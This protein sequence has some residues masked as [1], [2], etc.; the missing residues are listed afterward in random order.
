MTHLGTQ[1]LPCGRVIT[2]FISSQISLDVSAYIYGYQL[3]RT[4]PIHHGLLY[5]Q[6]PRRRLK[7]VCRPFTPSELATMVTV[8]LNCQNN[9]PNFMLIKSH[10][11]TNMFELVGI[12]N[13]K[14]CSYVQCCHA[15][16]LQDYSGMRVM[17]NLDHVSASQFVFVLHLFMR[18]TRLQQQLASEASAVCIRRRPDAML[19]CNTECKV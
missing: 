10:N 11:I 7:D 4:A 1:R 17:F 13:S 18:S 14:S 6:L 15:S 9:F 2:A 12:R 19:P 8:L 3:A 16:T 5:D